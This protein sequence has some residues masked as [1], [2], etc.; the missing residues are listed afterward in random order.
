MR[1]ITSATH[2]S[3][4]GRPPTPE[5]MHGKRKMRRRREGG[6]GEDEGEEE[7]EEGAWTHECGGPDVMHTD[8]VH[9]RLEGVVAEWVVARIA[10]WLRVH[11]VATLEGA[12]QSPSREIYRDKGREERYTDR[13][14]DIWTWIDRRRDVANSRRQRTWWGTSFRFHARRPTPPLTHGFSRLNR[15]TQ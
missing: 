4:E 9:Y 12:W 10:S 6:E 2:A 7:D 1:P 14:V 13:W 15:A 11:R 8:Y 5:V 3:G